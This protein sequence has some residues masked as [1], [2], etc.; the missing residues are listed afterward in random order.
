MC[1][2]RLANQWIRNSTSGE[3]IIKGDGVD[4]AC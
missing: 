4:F 3:K 2:L 1:S